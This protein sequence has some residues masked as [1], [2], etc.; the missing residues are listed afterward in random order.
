MFNYFLQLGE[1]CKGISYLQSI[2]IVKVSESL[3][4]WKGGWPQT[5]MYNITPK[6]HTSKNI[7]QLIAIKIST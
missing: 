5:N 4:S 2:I 7:K 3:A 6:D 1:T